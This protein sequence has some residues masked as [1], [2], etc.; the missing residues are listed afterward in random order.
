MKPTITK[1]DNSQ[2]EIS[3]EIDTA[4]FETYRAQAVEALGQDAV[5]DG[6]RPGHV[7]EKVLIQKLGEEKV[8]LEMSRLA[9]GELYP[10]IVSEEKLDVIGRPEITITKMAAGN[11][12]GYK[13]TTAIMPEVKLPDY[14]KIA[15]AI[16]S[17]PADLIVITDEDV[18]KV[19]E[20]LRAARGHKHD[21]GEDHL[22]ELNDEFAKSLGQF[23]SLE[24][25][26]NKVKENLKLERERE[27]KEKH[28]LKIVEAIREETIVPVPPV[29]LEAELDKMVSELKMQIEHMGLKF[30][31]YLKHI[32]KEESAM[33]VDWQAD[34]E[35]R[36]KVGLILNAIAASEQVKPDAAKVEAEMKHFLGHYPDAEP[37]RLKAYVENMQI[38]EATFVFLESLK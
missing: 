35:K 26:K 9:L 28:R 17:E 36:V 27:A 10:R 29:L 5:V 12:L 15:T 21:D 13:I 14:K 31:E 37:E 22:P 23:E 24:D 25:L 11:P 32:K 20:E 33:R 19:L 8:L 38:H 34:A 30:D 3:G 2:V 6:F 16:N 4:L 18:A 1:L 7:P